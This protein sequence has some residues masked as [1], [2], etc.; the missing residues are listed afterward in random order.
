[1]TSYRFASPDLILLEI[2]GTGAEA[3]RQALGP[4]EETRPVTRID[5][6]ELPCIALI[7]HPFLRAA[8]IITEFAT[9]QDGAS[10]ARLP[11]LT[12][13]G[14][15]DI[16]ENPRAPLDHSRAYPQ[17]QL[18]AALAPQTHPIRHL[19][20][21]TRI[22]Q[23]ETLQSAPPDGLPKVAPPEVTA[24]PGWPSS[25]TK[26]LSKIYTKDFSLLGYSPDQPKPTGEVAPLAPPAPQVWDLWPAFF[27]QHD[28]RI[29]AAAQAL[30]APGVDLAPFATAV[31]GGR[32]GNTWAG[33]EP[34]LIRHFRKLQP[35]FADQSRLAHLLAATVVILRRD[36]EC[37][38]AAELFHEITID[39]SLQ[40]ASEMK[41]RWLVSVTDTFA[42]LGRNQG[43]RAMGI[44]GSL[45]ANTLKLSETERRLYAV[46]RPWPPQRRLAGGGALF[47]G[48]ITYWVEK[49]EMITLMTERLERVCAEDPQAGPFTREILRRA[50][51]HNTVYKRLSDLAGTTP[52]PLL[53]A[54]LTEELRKLT[55]D[56]L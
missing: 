6:P 31:V 3:L 53:D 33:R 46:P 9:P 19:H 20:T 36:P 44:A 55:S 48:M 40:L 10:A 56:L 5:T 11:G 54:E 17:A 32:R 39:H 26:R 38:E 13:E 51:R 45:L 4:P 25:I 41:L 30:P 21:A 16:L 2:P 28:V 8:R 37:R 34:N 1:M 52:P 47:D 35:E 15:L 29:A 27:D 14:A 7:A 18:K 12:L 23:S 43:Q 49:G 42:D 50:H 22:L 24:L